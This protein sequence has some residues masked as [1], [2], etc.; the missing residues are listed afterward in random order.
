MKIKKSDIKKWT[1]A[2]DSEKY[3]QTVAELE[4]RFGYCCLGV[5]CRL[6]I[7]LKKIKLRNKKYLYGTT[8]QKQ[9]N[10]PLWLKEIDYDFQKKTGVTLSW[11]NDN[12]LDESEHFTSDN[13]TF[14]EIATVLELVYVH[15]ILENEN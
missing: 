4:D 9:P 1:S 12:G 15:N 5:A 10:A 14:G 3:E 13:F 11:L 7:P 8:P 2:L 6:F